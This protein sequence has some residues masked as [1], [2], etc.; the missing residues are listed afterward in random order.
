M[1]LVDERSSLSVEQ[2]MDDV[3]GSVP[4]QPLG[5]EAATVDAVFTK[6]VFAEWLVVAEHKGDVLSWQVGLLSKKT[7]QRRRLGV[8]H[9]HRCFLPFTERVR[10]RAS[11][12]L[13][14][15]GDLT[16]LTSRRLWVGQGLSK[17]TCSRSLVGMEASQRGSIQTQPPRWSWSTAEM[18]DNLHVLA[19]A[20]AG[21][22]GCCRRPD[23]D[24]EASRS[25][26][27]IVERQFATGHRTMADDGKAS[28]VKTPARSIGG[29]PRRDPVRCEVQSPRP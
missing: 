11:T 10:Q 23:Q 13:K 28:H 25:T 4:L 22:Q 14:A 16:P 1:A 6:V 3:H 29:W 20:V 21:Q 8:K 12:L 7:N 5:S 17:H 2:P 26:G 9:E 24:V 18:E 27:Q 15:S 19:K